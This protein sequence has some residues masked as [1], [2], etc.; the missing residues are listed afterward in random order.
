MHVVTLERGVVAD[1]GAEYPGYLERFPS[2][3]A[4]GWSRLDG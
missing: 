1:A 3:Y 4:E 2:L